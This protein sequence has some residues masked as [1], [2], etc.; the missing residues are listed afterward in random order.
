MQFTI[1]LAILPILV[2]A[3]SP[4]F[5]ERIGLVIGSNYTGNQAG[6]PPLE[7]TETDARLMEDTLKQKGTFDS[8]KVL[9]AREV[10]ASNVKKEIDG[11]AAKAGKDDTVVVYFSG[12]G[13]MQQDSSAPNGYRNYLIMFNRPHLSDEMLDG[14]LS[15]IDSPKT[16]LIMDACFSGGIADRGRKGVGDV[17][18]PAGQ[19]GVVLENQSSAMFTE[20]VIVASSAANETSVEVHGTINH[21][22]FTYYFS[23]GMDPKNGDMNRDKSVTILEAFEWSKK[24]VTN[25][26]MRLKKRQN[27]QVAG[28]AA[29]V[30]VTG[31]EPEPPKVEE[32][33]QAPTTS[34]P[35]FPPPVP[36]QAE[37]VQET[38]ANEPVQVVQVTQ[39][40]VTTQEPPPQTGTGA[41][42]GN[43]TIITTIYRSMLAGPAPMDPAEKLRRMKAGDRDRNIRVALS[44]KEIPARVEWVD[45]KGLATISGETIPLGNYSSHGR[46]KKNQVA[47]IH[48]NGV[49]AGVQAMAISAEGYPILTDRVAVEKGD[50]GKLMIVASLSGYG[51][52]QGKVFHKNFDTPL[53]GQS[54]W[55]PTVEAPNVIHKVVS[56][57]DG[58]FWFL[59]LPPGEHYYIKP[60][61]AEE[62]P[63]DNKQLEVKDG[64]VT[65]VD[66]VL[67]APLRIGSGR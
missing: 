51:S 12:H 8:V 3:V 25:M 16:V 1:R 62:T 30:V 2:L 38:P 41:V 60:S 14:W 27:P 11:I 18:I 26:A 61:F 13:T 67:K 39:A 56:Q 32:V 29:G 34:Q 50:E 37:P 31:R 66:V 9:L 33:A 20:R 17:P 43:Y 7:L 52:I 49:P 55:M 46:L 4:V 5:G 54:I 22:L 24:R 59:N 44:G 15:E 45:E 47:V 21:G 19:A 48:L 36:A 28:R 10:T 35:T 57:S 53:A 65:T 6:I 63:L 64:Q 23:Q 58:S 42:T 40:P